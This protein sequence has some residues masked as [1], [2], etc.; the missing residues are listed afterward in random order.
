M[1]ACMPLISTRTH[2]EAGTGCEGAERTMTQPW[3]ESG[4]KS[5]HAATYQKVKLNGTLLLP[6]CR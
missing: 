3:L 1:R 2:T 5:N 6:I 4:Q